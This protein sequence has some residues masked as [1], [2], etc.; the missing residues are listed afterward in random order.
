MITYLFQALLL[1]AV[2]YGCHSV[3]KQICKPSTRIQ[4][5]VSDEQLKRLHE[6]LDELKKEQDCDTEQPDNTTIS[7]TQMEKDL[8]HFMKED[9]RLS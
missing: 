2:V 6:T 8:E 5:I 1:L 3:W 7:L 4:N 9:M